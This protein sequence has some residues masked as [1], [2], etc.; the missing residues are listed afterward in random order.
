MSEIIETLP[1]I[2]PGMESNRRYV[3]VLEVNCRSCSQWK[4]EIEYAPSRLKCYAPICRECDQEQRNKKHAEDPRKRRAHAAVARAIKD[5]TLV[6]GPC[7]KC[8]ITETVSGHHD[9]Y[10][11]PLEVRWLC[12][13]HHGDIHRK[14]ASPVG[15]AAG[16][17][18]EHDTL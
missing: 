16:I 3:R 13:E 5:G 17:T 1:P 7:E 14:S 8:G 10:D 15:D 12:Q 11:K 2:I 4:L 6:K 18:I 9:D